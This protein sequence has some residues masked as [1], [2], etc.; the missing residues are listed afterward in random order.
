[1][2]LADRARVEMDCRIGICGSDNIFRP[3]FR[4]AQDQNGNR[5]HGPTRNSHATLL[6]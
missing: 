6:A 3:T 5:Q 1:M 4:D 2:S